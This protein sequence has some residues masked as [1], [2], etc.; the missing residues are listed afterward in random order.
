MSG[1][2]RKVEN[3]NE[4]NE[5]IE[6]DADFTPDE[7]VKL[8]AAIRPFPTI[9]NMKSKAKRDADS[10]FNSW[11]MK[12]R[13]MLLPSFFSKTMQDMF[14]KSKKDVFVSKT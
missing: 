5:E 11:Q 13:G 12:K 8:V 4:D 9:W 6:G 7:K 10:V 14:D 1:K 3:E 2:K